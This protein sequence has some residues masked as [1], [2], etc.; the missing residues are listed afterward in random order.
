MDS[1]KLLHGNSARIKP[2]IS[3]APRFTNFVSDNYKT[4]RN[5]TVYHNPL[6]AD[7]ERAKAEVDANKL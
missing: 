5:G 3:L 7:E 1:K 2:D 6:D 4:T